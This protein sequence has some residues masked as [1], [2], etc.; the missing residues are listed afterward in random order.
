M[1]FDHITRRE[2][3][4]NIV[5]TGEICEGRGKGRLERAVGEEE[6]GD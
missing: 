5:K 6:E 1:G 3:L 4:E 2:A